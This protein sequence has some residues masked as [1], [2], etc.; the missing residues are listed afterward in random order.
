MQWD[1][2]TR[3]CVRMSCKTLS[4]TTG[5]SACAP[6]QAFART[7]VSDRLTFGSG[8]SMRLAASHCCTMCVWSMLLSTG[9]PVVLGMEGEAVSDGMLGSCKLV[10]RSSRPGMVICAHMLGGQ[11]AMSKASSGVLHALQQPPASSSSSLC[12]PLCSHMPQTPPKKSMFCSA[13]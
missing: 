10:A 2:G 13:S 7:L 5:G 3:A 1:V 9:R 12:L 8:T 11:R 4:T 6:T